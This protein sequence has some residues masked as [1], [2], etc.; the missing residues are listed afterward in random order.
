MHFRHKS[1]APTVLALGFVCCWGG[2]ILLWH[3]LSLP[4]SA[5]NLTRLLL[6]LGLPAA[7]CYAKHAG[8]TAADLGLSLRGSAPFLRKDFLLAVAGVGL[9]VL[10][11][12]LLCLLFPARFTAA[13]F[14][15][16]SR[17]DLS[18]WLY[19]LSVAAQQFLSQGFLHGLF[20]RSMAGSHGDSC[21]LAATVAVFSLLHMHLG[22]VYMLGAAAM[23]LVLGRLY[24]R[25]GSIWGLCIIHYA[26]GMAGGYLGFL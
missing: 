19:P 11:K 8:L 24:R 3:V 9:L 14:W 12:L 17:T 25:Q 16:W 21:A 18:Y 15:D 10:L 20:R 5:T 26:L 4:I 23:L 13:P 22:I 2:F 1:P 7:F 6:L